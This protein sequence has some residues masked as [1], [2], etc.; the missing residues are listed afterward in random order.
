MNSAFPKLDGSQNRTLQS[1]DTDGSVLNPP[2]H[3]P[4]HTKLYFFQTFARLLCSNNRAAA[5]N[6]KGTAQLT[7]PSYLT[8]LYMSCLPDILYIAPSEIQTEVN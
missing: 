6:A 2:F 8:N 7:Y 5:I 1:Q 4:G 3:L